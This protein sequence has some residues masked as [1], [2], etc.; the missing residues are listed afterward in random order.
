MTP[1]I[2]YS[3]RFV[4]KGHTGLEQLDDAVK[5]IESLFGME[6]I[7]T[8]VEGASSGKSLED[9]FYAAEAAILN[10]SPAILANLR[11][12]ISSVQPRTVT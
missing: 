3:F 11:S 12:F 10:P 2:H 1:L 9:T 5:A 4:V 8:R 7:L 6:I